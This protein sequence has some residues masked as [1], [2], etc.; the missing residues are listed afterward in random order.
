ML[1]GHSRRKKKEDAMTLMKWKNPS[2]GLERQN[3]LMP[4]VENFF[5]DFFNGDFYPGKLAG[6][7]PSVNIAETDQSYSIEVSAPGF[8]KKDFN[9]KV[10][11]GMLIISGEHKTEK[12]DEEKN[13]V[14][15]EFNYGSF[16]RSFNLADSIDE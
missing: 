14:R 7:T 10:E 3:L 2:K 12:K 8:E 4:S 11:D 9:V 13:F 5:N 1:S 6:Q 16:S 15:R